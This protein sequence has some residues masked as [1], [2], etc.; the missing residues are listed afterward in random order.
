[1]SR[2]YL[3]LCSVATLFSAV[4]LPAAASPGGIP[5]AV[6]VGGIPPAAALPAESAQEEDAPDAIH[7]VVL[8]TNDVHGQALPREATWIDDRDVTVGGLVRVAEY[9]ARVRDEHVGPGKGVL[10]V[11]G[12][13]WFQGTPEGAVDD[14]LP[15]VT[16]L[17]AVGYDA[18]TL[19]NHEFDL[20]VDPL[21]RI[22][23]GAGPPAVCANLRLAD[24]SA[25]VDWVEPW[26]VVECAGLRVAIVGLVEQGTPFITHPDARQFVFEEEVQAL[27]RARTE[28][29][30]QYDLLLPLTHCGVDV[31]RRLAEA[32]PD[33]PLIV[34]GHSHTFLQR[35]QRSGATLIAQAGSK[36][37]VVGRVDLIFDADSGAVRSASARL[38]ELERDPA[39]EPR[40]GVV[41]D[42]VAALVAAAEAALG[43]EVGELL[44]PI[45][46][47]GPL[48]SSGVGNWIADSFRAATG[49][50]L[51]IHNRGGIRTRLIPG[52]LTR[53]DLFELLPFPNTVVVMELTGAELIAA[54]EGHLL[55]RGRSRL[56]VSG[57][58]IGFALGADGTVERVEVEVGGEAIEADRTYRVATNSFLADGGD[59]LFELER[60]VS[61]LD[62]G[63][64]LR[65][66]LERQLRDEGR[67]GTPNDDRYRSL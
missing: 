60:D 32:N 49:A 28:L 61:R 15:F 26:R 67:V 50:D 31:D 53:R 24:D 63:T 66:L 33:L 21:K 30:G 56:E 58:S 18:M 3:T 10:V 42:G 62:T 29:E 46:E 41:A 44:G 20:G 38:I 54:V 4:L 17:T 35:G 55:G 48:R 12:G 43:E 65:E 2:I 57:M 40:N 25:R 34:G 47:G 64:L 13:D 9:V 39:G 51:G 23:A 11:D 8:H 6:S 45:E 7:L 27:A 52:P 37:T 5:G 19:G 14:G 1:M 16:A 22:L 59:R 36:A